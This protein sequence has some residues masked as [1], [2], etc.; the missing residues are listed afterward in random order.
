MIKQ[1]LTL[2]L[3]YILATP[4]VACGKK[5]PLDPPDGKK[6]DYPRQYP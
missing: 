6:I 4:L 5:G 3:I 1:I 2:I